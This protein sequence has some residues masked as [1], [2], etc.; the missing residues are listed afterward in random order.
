MLG[1]T[2]NMKSPF[3]WLHGNVFSQEIFVDWKKVLIFVV[4]LVFRSLKDL[5]SELIKI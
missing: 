3:P 5:N 2:E 1:G 4:S